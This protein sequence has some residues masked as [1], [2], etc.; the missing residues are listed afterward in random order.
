MSCLCKSAK[1]VKV[2]QLLDSSTGTA[3]TMSNPDHLSEAELRVALDRA[4]ADIFR[5]AMRIN[6]LERSVQALQRPWPRSASCTWPVVSLNSTLKSNAWR[7]T[8]NI[9]RP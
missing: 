9:R 2:E 8:T 1:Q 6:N 3:A 4:N 7:P 5:Q